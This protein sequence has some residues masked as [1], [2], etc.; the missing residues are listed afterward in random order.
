MLSLFNGRN[1]PEDTALDDFNRTCPRCGKEGLEKRQLDNDHYTIVCR[2]C[3]LKRGIL[4][5][6]TKK[7][8][9]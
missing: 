3:E 4:K 1:S 2:Y 5:T 8:V 7:G 6:D 9:V